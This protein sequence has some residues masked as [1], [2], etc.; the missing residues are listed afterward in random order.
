M[1]PLRPLSI[2]RLELQAATIGVRLMKSITYHNVRLQRRIM[3]TD[4]K[5]VLTWLG[6]D[7]RKY[8]QFVMFCIATILKETNITE[9]RWVPTALNVAD[10]AT[11]F[12]PVT[13]N[14]MEWF[15]GPSWL[16]LPE[17]HWPNK[18]V[19][20]DQNLSDTQMSEIRPRYLNLHSRKQVMI[21]INFQYFSSWY[22]L[23]RGVANWVMY[24]ERKLQ[25]LK[26]GKFV[27]RLNASHLIRAKKII[28]KTTQVTSFADEYFALQGGRPSTKGGAFDGLN[29]YM[30]DDGVVRVKNRAQYATTACGPQRDLIIL[31]SKH[32]VT[33]LIIME[34]HRAYHHL[35]HETVLNKIRQIY[36]IIKL[37]AVFKSVRRSCQQCKIVG[38]KPNTPQMAP[39]PPVRLGAFQRPFTFVGVDCFGPITV[40]FGRKSLK[41][42]GVIF[43]CLTIRAIHIEIAHTL[44]TDSFLMTLTN[45]I[46][47]RGIP[48]EIYSD[49]GTNFRGADRFL[50]EEL[51]TLSSIRWGKRW[52]TRAFHGSLIPR[53]LLIWGELGK[54]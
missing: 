19:T 38:A 35:N 51:K 23:K 40:T 16:K 36:F 39:L 24:V 53:P 52:L 30:D 10:F 12:R 9:W 25:K 22:R 4:S 49:N 20:P 18:S 15:E 50:K 34:Y 54:G 28:L 42:W 14:Y 41:R 5:T 7:P 45:F 33:K 29:I 32:H 3:W 26:Q 13:D 43:T 8:K 46:A 37:R 6:G 27:E 31:P 44:S 1:A 11:K 2:P 47:R 21:S 17:S 48:A